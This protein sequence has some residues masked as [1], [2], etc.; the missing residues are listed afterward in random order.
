MSPARWSRPYGVVEAVGLVFSFDLTNLDETMA[1]RRAEMRPSRVL[2]TK[3][4]GS[5][6]STLVFLPGLGGTT[7]YWES[8]VAPLASEH[9]L[10]LIDLL[11]FGRSPKPWIRYTVE[12]HVAELRRVLE[13]REDFTLVGH[14][15]GA[16]AAVAY[17]ARYP[18]QVNG[19]VL[20]SLPCFGGLEQA[21]AYYRRRGGPDRWLMTNVVL[22]AVT[23]VVTRRIL[24]R[25]LPRLLADMPREVAEDLVQHTWL[26]STSTLWEGVYRHDVARDADRLPKEN[27][28][29]V[30]ARGSGCDGTARVRKATDR[31]PIPMDAARPGRRRSSPVA[32]RPGPLPRCHPRVRGILEARHDRVRMTRVDRVVL[33]PETSE[34]AARK[35]RSPEAAGEIRAM[36]RQSPQ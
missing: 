8:R 19:L 34:P 20:L 9:C 36:S 2:Y 18:E 30:P 33:E 16:L 24:R 29:A 17:A 26:S 7:R 14:S 1:P 3:E 25:L 15:F 13:G 35:A 32:P 4:L 5:G 10:L 12:R 11:G 6:G 27:A 23:C 28:G 31:G 21:I 22:A